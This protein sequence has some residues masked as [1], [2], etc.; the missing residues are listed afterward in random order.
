MTEQPTAKYE[1]FVNET[2]G[3]TE[4]KITPVLSDIDRMLAERRSHVL[5]VDEIAG[6]DDIL[7]ALEYVPEWGGSVRVRQFSKEREFEIRRQATVGG[8]VDPTRLE[9][10]LVVNGVVEPELTEEH[11][12]MLASKSQRAV[13]RVLKKIVALNA[14][15]DEEAEKA[16]ATFLDERGA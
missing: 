13:D 4:A 1:T 14:I 3:E 7:E 6:A 2:T 5:T 11:V 12:G 15:S 10:L 16:I 9:M 8:K